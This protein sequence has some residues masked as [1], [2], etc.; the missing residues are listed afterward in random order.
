M[1]K[2]LSTFL[3]TAQSLMLAAQDPDSTIM[4]E[5]A[6]HLM[7]KSMMKFQRDFTTGAVVSLGGT[8][9]I[10]AGSTMEAQKYSEKTKSYNDNDTRK[11]VMGAGAVFALIGYI[12]QISSF[13]H[14]KEAGRIRYKEGKLVMRIGK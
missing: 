2:I 5:Q 13:S 14:L 9:M 10:I 6:I 7:S 8:M 4:S 12:T 3:I 11:L 1:K